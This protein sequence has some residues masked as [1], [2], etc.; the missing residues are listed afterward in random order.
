MIIIVIVTALQIDETFL[1]HGGSSTGSITTVNNDEAPINLSD[2]GFAF[3]VSS[4]NE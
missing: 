4:V 3:A 2:L 1:R